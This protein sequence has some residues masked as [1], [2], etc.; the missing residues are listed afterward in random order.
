MQSPCLSGQG[1]E[2]QGHLTH[3]YGALRTHVTRVGVLGKGACCWLALLVRRPDPA[4][5]PYK[6]YHR[7]AR[8][9]CAQLTLVGVV[10]R[11][12]FGTVFEGRWRGL[13]VAVK[14][15]RLLAD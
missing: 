15:V 14:T 11:G 12:A 4:S 9:H 3:L 1:D 8:L 6:H 5:A 13:K 7:Q 2:V 10:G